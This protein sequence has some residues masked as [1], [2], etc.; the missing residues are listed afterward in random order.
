MILL[1]IFFVFLKIGL[2]T[3]GGGYAMIPFVQ[4]EAVEV[5]GWI[6]QKEFAE[7]VALDTV[8]PGPIAVN[9]ATFVGY[10]VS[11]VIGAITATLGV[12]LPSLI[13]VTLIAIFFSSFKNSPIV[14][15][16]LKGLKPAVVALIAVAV[17]SLIKQKAI[18]DIGTGVIA[19]I[20]FLGVLILNV[21]PIW[22]V[23]LAGTAGFLIYYVK[24][25]I[26]K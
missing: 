6:T 9:L 23:I 7:I 11:G 17:I 3:V 26:S 12:I 1:K 4:K 13:I 25:I 8:T 10:K 21:H 19:L 15:S 24:D 2:F 16:I 14:Q 18:V 5:N 20:V 22:M